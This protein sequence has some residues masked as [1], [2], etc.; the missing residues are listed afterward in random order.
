MKEYPL[1]T[2]DVLVDVCEC[3]HAKHYHEVIDDKCDDCTCPKYNFE[4]QMTIRN[5]LK[6]SRQ[7]R[8]DRLTS[9]FST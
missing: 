9:G 7:I 8:K 2:T 1:R 5:A 4:Q 6:L 3:G